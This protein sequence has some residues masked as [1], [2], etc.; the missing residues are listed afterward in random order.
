MQRID[1]PLAG[2]AARH[3][4]ALVAVGAIAL[5]RD[6]FRL[7]DA[8]ALGLALTGRWSRWPPAARRGSTCGLALAFG[9]AAGYAAYVLA[10]DGIMRRLAPLQLGALVCAGRRSRSPAPAPRPAS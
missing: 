9:A 5:R 1:A 4:P 3:L 6:R 10:A 7:R 2:P 8:I